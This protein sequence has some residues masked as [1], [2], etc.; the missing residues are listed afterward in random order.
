[1][2]RDVYL[3]LVGAGVSLASTVVTLVFQFILN[4]IVQKSKDKKELITRRSSEIRAA[5]LE[6]V[7]DPAE[8][9]R[10]LREFQVRLME[11]EPIG[12]KPV[13]APERSSGCISSRVVLIILVAFMMGGC[14]FL[15]WLF[16]IF[17]VLPR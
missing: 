9:E 7:H 6:G 5:L 15:L 2:D 3:I 17:V 10:L 12:I 8:Q 11:K 1:V 14:I 4:N 16:S 13:Q